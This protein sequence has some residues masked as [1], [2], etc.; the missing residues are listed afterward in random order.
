[1]PALTSSGAGVSS[2]HA[3]S[4]VQPVARRSSS[5]ICHWP[6]TRMIVD[7]AL[8]AAHE[9][10]LPLH[11]EGDVAVGVDVGRKPS[12][13]ST[14][15]TRPRSGC[16]SGG[17]REVRQRRRIVSCVL[18]VT[19]SPQPC[20]RAMP[21]P[22]PRPRP[23]AAAR[24]DAGRGRG[25]RRRLRR[26]RRRRSSSA[27]STPGDATGASERRVP[28]RR[29]RPR[30]VVRLRP[31]IGP[32]QRYGVRVHGPWRPDDGACAQPGQAA[33]RPLRPGLE[34]R[35]TWRP[36]VFGHVVDARCTATRDVR[37]ARDSAPY[38]PALRR[39]GRRRVRLGRRRAA[40]G[41][42]GRHGHLRGARQASPGGTRT[43]PR[44]LRG[45]YAG[46]A[47]PA[48]LAHL[49]RPR[50][51]VGRAAARARVHPRAG[52]GAARA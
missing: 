17:R 47:H 28:L 37:D 9:Q 39:R 20:R 33:A 44:T 18:T 12:S 7:V 30:L 4:W 23:A 6:K 13:T 27:C 31:G 5:P 25:R 40:A 29:A 48:T 15:S 8:D 16:S 38:V 45:T 26:A 1:M 22:G 24:R 36:E 49:H 52:T 43:C 35:V 14:S 46:L 51:D 10:L 42:V 19:D 41:A 3:S 32:G 2:L 11:L 21:A 34:R 50:R